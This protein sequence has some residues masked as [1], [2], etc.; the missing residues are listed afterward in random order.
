[1][2]PLVIFVVDCEDGEGRGLDLGLGEEGSYRGLEDEV[3]FEVV[4]TTDLTIS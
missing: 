4:E 1:V 3:V 2:Q